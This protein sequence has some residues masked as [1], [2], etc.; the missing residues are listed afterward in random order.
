MTGPATGPKRVYAFTCEDPE[1]QVARHMAG[2]G[3][4]CARPDM[5]ARALRAVR[6]AA[7]RG[8]RGYDPARHAALLRLA[9]GRPPS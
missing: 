5:L 7:L 9:R 2:L 3:I 8:G 1:A 6:K 4:L